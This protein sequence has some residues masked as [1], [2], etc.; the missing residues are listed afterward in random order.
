MILWRSVIHGSFPGLAGETLFFATA[1]GGK[2]NLP[3]WLPAAA[4]S[5]VT[6]AFIYA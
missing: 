1:S 6:I 3:S 2:K 4:I 5:T